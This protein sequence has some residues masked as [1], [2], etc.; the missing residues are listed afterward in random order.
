[1][2]DHSNCKH[3]ATKVARAAC[4]RNHALS[5]SQSLSES[6]EHHPAGK[7][8]PRTRLPSMIAPKLR[9]IVDAAKAKGLKIRVATDPAEGVEQAFVIV[10]PKKPDCE[11][12]AEIFKSARRGFE[13]R[14]EFFHIE[15]GRSRQLSRQRA[16]ADIDTLAKT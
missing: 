16:M 4:R 10:N 15:G 9:P 2:F 7:S 14:A 13:G 5:E 8:V 6:V 1:M 3:A 12:I 11:L